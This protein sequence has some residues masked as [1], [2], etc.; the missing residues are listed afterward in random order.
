[1]GNELKKIKEAVDSIPISLPEQ[2]YVGLEV[3]LPTQLTEFPL[4]SRIMILWSVISGENN[5]NYV[6]QGR[7][8]FSILFFSIIFN[9]YVY[10]GGKYGGKKVVFRDI[11]FEI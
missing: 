4:F 8:I 6:S 1:M 7:F 9:K 11:P 10:S 2:P 5:K 3:K